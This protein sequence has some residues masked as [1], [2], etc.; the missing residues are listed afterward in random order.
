MKAKNSCAFALCFLGL[1]AMSVAVIGAATLNAAPAFAAQP[2]VKDDGEAFLGE[3]GDMFMEEVI[4]PKAK[5]KA[6]PKPTIPIDLSRVGVSVDPHGN[7]VPIKDSADDPWAGSGVK[8]FMNQIESTFTPLPFNGFAGP[9]PYGYGVPGYNMPGYVNPNLNYRALG[10]PNYGY[11]GYGYPGYGYPQYGNPYGYPNYRPGLSINFGGGRGG[12][13]FGNPGYYNGFNGYNGF[14]NGYYG[15]GF[16]GGYTPWNTF[17]SFAG[18]GRP[19]YGYGNAGY[20]NL[21]YG[22]PYGGYNPYGYPAV[23]APLATFN[24]G[25][26]Q[27]AI[28]SSGPGIYPNAANS[29]FFPSTTNYSQSSMWRAFN[30]AF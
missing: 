22:N 13:S 24:I 15:G 18:G 10:Y 29:V 2:A 6:K 30:L 14:N 9:T 11:P 12:I 26:F 21:G 27:G 17:N 25:K 20:G 1:S 4:D 28:G 16:G 5:A 3:N 19:Y 23:G 8:P 7:I